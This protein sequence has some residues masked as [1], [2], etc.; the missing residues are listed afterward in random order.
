MAWPQPHRPDR[1][2]TWLVGLNVLLA[3][4]LLVGILKNGGAAGVVAGVQEATANAKSAARNIE[5]TQ[6]RLPKICT[7][8]QPTCRCC[9]CD[10]EKPRP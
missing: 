8:C 3:V 9:K 10:E 1:S 7:D 2:L 5:D 4:I 6:E